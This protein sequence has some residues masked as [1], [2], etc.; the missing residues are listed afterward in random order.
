LSCC[1]ARTPIVWVAWKHHVVNDQRGLPLRK[2]FGQ[3]HARRVAAGS[4]AVVEDIV[5]RN[6]TS[7][8]KRS[9]CACKGFYPTPKFYLFAK[10]SIARGSIFRDSPGKV[11]GMHLDYTEIRLN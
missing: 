1:S 6:D 10:Q 4:G 11:T 8:R 7:L 9:A 2:E 3:P 5:F